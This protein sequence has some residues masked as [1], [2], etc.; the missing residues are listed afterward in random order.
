[1]DKECKRV[2]EWVSR[3]DLDDGYTI[4]NAKYLREY[5]YIREELKHYSA[6]L[7]VL[8][9]ELEN[10]Y[11]T[12]MMY[13]AKRQAEFCGAVCAE[14]KHKKVDRIHWKLFERDIK[15]LYRRLETIERITK[16]DLHLTEYEPFFNTFDDF[17]GFDGEYKELAKMAKEWNE[18][19][20]DEV[21]R[22]MEEVRP[23]IERHNAYIQRNVEA[24]KKERLEMRARRKAE[25]DEVRAIKQNAEKHRREYKKIE[26]SFQRYYNGG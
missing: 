17:Y 24:R 11:L 8:G 21:L 5:S 2:N 10:H 25:N 3:Q 13:S 4:A 23:E 26:R 22:H 19:H 6:I 12:K 9:V 20:K 18:E 14:L 15:S 7:Y 1:M 16:E